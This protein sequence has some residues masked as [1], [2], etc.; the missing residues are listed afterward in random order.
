[1]F[2]GERTPSETKVIKVQLSNSSP[3]RI[4]GCFMGGGGG[5]WLVG[6]FK[7]FTANTFGLLY[8]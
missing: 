8:L 1:M 7:V 5:E 3:G 6:E 4:Q 2:E